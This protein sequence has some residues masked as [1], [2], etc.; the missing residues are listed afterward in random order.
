[1]R[2]TGEFWTTQQLT[3]PVL[4]GQ[5]CGIPAQCLILGKPTGCVCYRKGALGLKLKII[6]FNVSFPEVSCLGFCLVGFGGFVWLECFDFFV[7]LR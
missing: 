5:E 4:P 6:N 2:F 3:K 1:M 7:S